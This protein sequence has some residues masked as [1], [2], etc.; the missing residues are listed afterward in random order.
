MTF[1]DLEQIRKTYIN[2]K[3]ECIKKVINVAL[4]LCL[5]LASII[6]LTNLPKLDFTHTSMLIEFLLTFFV[7]ALNISVLTFIVGFFYVMAKTGDDHKTYINA[8]K[9]YFITST[10]KKVF[11][12][13]SYRHDLALPKEEIAKTAMM[14]MGDRYASNDYTVAKYKGIGFKQADVWIQEEHTDSD[15]DTT[16]TTIF[17]GRYIIFDLNKDFTKKLLVVSK[18]FNAEKHDKTFKRIE[19]ES[20]EFN[21]KFDV[22]AQ[23]GFEAY[24]LLDPAV[25][26]RIMKLDEL[27]DGRIMVCFSDNKMHIAINNNTDSFEPAPA[28]KP[29]D[30]KK[31]FDKVINDIKVITN[32]IDEVK[33]TK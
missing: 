18:N 6:F 8:Y 23:D 19:L 7:T 17:R 2:K 20:N 5:G 10:F 28:N 3:N 14:Q 25:M 30:E 24:Y 33:L 15:G 13:I 22:F 9:Y 4:L 27:H 16:Y 31:E 21:K 1:E 26:E 11:T 12:D 29:I 32:I